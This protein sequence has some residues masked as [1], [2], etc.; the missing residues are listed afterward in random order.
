MDTWPALIDHN[1]SQS[2]IYICDWVFATSFLDA[3]SQARRTYG[4]NFEPHNVGWYGPASNNPT[5]RKGYEKGGWLYVEMLDKP[6][7]GCSDEDMDGSGYGRI[8]V[9]HIQ[10][11]NRTE[12][13][14]DASRMP[15]W[16]KMAV[17]AERF[18]AKKV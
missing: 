13:P 6:L 3:L 4:D 9:R 18:K 16:V 2:H 11:Y 10:T 17:L 14:P 15:P 5:P 7:S 8:A 1:N 12:H